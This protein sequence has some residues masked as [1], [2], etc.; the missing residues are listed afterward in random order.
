MATTVDTL[1]YAVGGGHGHFI[2]GRTLQERLAAEG[3][4]TLLLAR[5]GSAPDGVAPRGDVRW[6]KG[7]G[8]AIATAM[9]DVRAESILVDTFPGGWR[10][11]L[12][13]DVLTRFP[14]RVLVARYR[15][16]VDWDKVGA[17]YE[18]LLLPY[19]VDRNEWEW[20]P[21]HASF[22]GFIVRRDAPRW[23]REGRDLVLVDTHRRCR[24]ALVDVIQRCAVRHGLGFR[25]LDRIGGDLRASRA[26]VV[27]A[28]YNTFYELIL[29]GA[30]ARFFPLERRHDD[31]YR[32]ASL[33][34]RAITGLAGLDAWLGDGPELVPADSGGI[35]IADSL[36]V[37]TK[38]KRVKR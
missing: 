29:Q 30:E 12:K 34:N 11:E 8:E 19:P 6:V 9:E 33:W 32:R 5:E 15:R 24:P 7:S 36:R 10:G 28:G 23:R 18:E 35:S 31:Q 27:G 17:V 13:G 3:R 14:R 4:S 2:R 16:Q 20:S 22:A 25:C 37:V 38:K 21:P 1:I 26:L